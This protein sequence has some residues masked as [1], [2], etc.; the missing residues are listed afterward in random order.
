MDRLQE[1]Y[2]LESFVLVGLCSGAVTSFQTALRDERVTGA[3][4]LN[5]QGFHHDPAW[6]AHVLSRTE[7]RRYVG[8]AMTDSSRWRRALSGR[9]DYRRLAGVLAARLTGWT[10]RT[11]TLSPVADELAAQFRSLA[12]R[13]VRLLVVCSDGDASVDYMEAILGREAHRARH[14]DTLLM[15][16]FPN[17]DHSLTLA[18]SQ[19]A[20]FDLIDSWA[21]VT[22]ARS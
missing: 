3:I 13:G 18:A 17:T 14:G 5:P 10:R 2:G 20:L 12:S 9:I 11:K 7:A 1:T 22:A 19:R 6:N 8:N 16:V 21:G 4:L 15:R